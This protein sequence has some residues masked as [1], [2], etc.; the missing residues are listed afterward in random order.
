MALTVGS[1]KRDVSF[2]LDDINIFIFFASK[3][4]LLHREDRVVGR[5]RDHDGELHTFFGYKNELFCK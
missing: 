4:I 1:L 5:S 2:F 3:Q